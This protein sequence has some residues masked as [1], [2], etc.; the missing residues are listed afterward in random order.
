MMIQQDTINVNDASEYNAEV[1]RS[2]PIGAQKSPHSL[3]K[4]L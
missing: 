1:N 2:H 4:S 3:C